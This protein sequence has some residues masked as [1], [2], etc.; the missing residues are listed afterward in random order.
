MDVL[1]YQHD[2]TEHRVGKRHA[3]MIFTACMSQLQVN[4]TFKSDLG[5]NKEGFLKESMFEMKLMDE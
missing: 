3:Q 5:C 4:T 2:T 1:G